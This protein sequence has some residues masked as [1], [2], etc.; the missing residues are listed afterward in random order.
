M[1]EAGEREC[2]TAIKSLNRQMAMR[3]STEWKDWHSY[4]QTMPIIMGGKKG[5]KTHWY[6]VNIFN[7]CIILNEMVSNVRMKMKQKALRFTREMR[8]LEIVI[9]ESEWLTWGKILWF[10]CST[11]WILEVWSD[12]CIM[13]QGIMCMFPVPSNYTNTES[14][15]AKCW[16]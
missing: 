1:N 13:I 5:G 12:K 8:K 2:Q 3:P 14:E 15:L 16:I 11:K 9:Q 4:V 10:L 6:G 7:V